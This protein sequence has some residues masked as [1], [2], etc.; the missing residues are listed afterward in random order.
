[1]KNALALKHV[2]WTKESTTRN[3]TVTIVYSEL[4]IALNYI[5]F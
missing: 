4:L 2:T 3:I 1:M 5:T